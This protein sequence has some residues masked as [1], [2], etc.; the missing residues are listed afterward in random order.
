M[1]SQLLQDMSQLPALPPRKQSLDP[2]PNRSSALGASSPRAL[3][4]R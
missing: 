1:T 4:P 3:T 2:L